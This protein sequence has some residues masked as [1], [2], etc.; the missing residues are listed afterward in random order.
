MILIF[1]REC[2]RA[3]RSGG[4]CVR[5]H[6]DTAETW[7]RPWISA[8]G[9]GVKVTAKV[10]AQTT[11]WMSGEAG[12]W[13]A[14]DPLSSLEG[15]LTTGKATVPWSSP[16]D[17]WVVPQGRCPSV[18]MKS[19]IYEEAENNCDYFSLLSAPC[20]IK[21]WGLVRAGERAQWLRILIAFLEDK[22][23]FP[24]SIWCLL[25]SHPSKF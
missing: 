17:S 6:S 24:V 4:M 8:Q 25:T 15:E 3:M 11:V 9:R 7:L 16:A 5:F 18:Q 21:K 2:W 10:S 13:C 20:V 23:W 14:R 22:V 1:E 12:H 19:K